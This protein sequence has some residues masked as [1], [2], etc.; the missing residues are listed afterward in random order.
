MT[1]RLGDL[2]KHFD[3]D[4]L[5]PI[6]GTIYRVPAPSIGEADRIR[7][8]LWGP[9]AT[10]FGPDDEWRE[11]VKILGTT[12]ADMLV[13]GVPAPYVSRAGRTALI[14]FCS[15]PQGPE[16]GRAHWHLADLADRIDTVRL[17][18]FLADEA[19]KRANAKAAREA[20]KDSSVVD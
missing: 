8:K 14:H 6:G 3:P 17:M 11:C 5:L 9:E 1:T 10:T 18:E 15:G 16:L 7:P 2:A 12:Y 19:E 13:D 20:M 4:L